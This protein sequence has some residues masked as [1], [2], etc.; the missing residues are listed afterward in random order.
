MEHQWK[1]IERGKTE[2]QGEESAPVSYHSVEH[3]SIKQPLGRTRYI[4]VILMCEE[5]ILFLGLHNS[6]T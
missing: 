2:F 1:D 4:T 6:Y 3:K 5:A